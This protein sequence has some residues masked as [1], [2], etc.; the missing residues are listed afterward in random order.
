[1]GDVGEGAAV[2]EGRRMLQS[3]YQVG[4]EGVLQQGCHGAFRLEVVGGNRLAVIG[5]AYDD[6]GQ[7][8]L[9]IHDIGCQ[10]EYSH[11]LGSNG[12]I[13]AV[14]SRHALQTST[15][16][17]HDMAELTV[18]HVDC[19]LPGDLLGIDAERIA[20]LDM[21]VE[22]GCQQVVGRA[23]GVEV[24]GKMQVDI[25]HGNHLGIAA[26]GSAALDAEDRS[27]RGLAKSE[28]YVLV[29]LAQS[30]SKAYRSGGLTLTGGGRGDGGHQ[31][32]LAVR[33]IRMIFQKA[34]IDLGFVVAV[35][36]D[37]LLVD[38]QKPA[39]SVIFLG[40]FSLR[41]LNITLVSHLFPSG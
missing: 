16:A 4:L 23:D 1:M 11:D 19:S 5:I 12:D 10:A 21:V 27:E 32:Q 22:H 39:I 28:N 2:D 26:A 40:W 13:K 8:G 31:D 29:D 33:L 38:P 34:V 35:L 15:Q 14:L 6:P 9:E 25:L 20:L 7:A 18:I 30:V 36:L 24:T 3:L 41:D 37:V 17:V